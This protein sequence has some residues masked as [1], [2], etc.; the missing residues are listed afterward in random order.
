MECVSDLTL[1]K[2]SSRIKAEPIIITLMIITPNKGN[3]F[4]F[5][6]LITEIP[7]DVKVYAISFMLKFLVLN[8]RIAKMA[9]KPKAIPISMKTEFSMEHMKKTI[10]AIKKKVNKNFSFFVY[11]K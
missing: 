7:I 3:L 4:S 11:L 10:M 8:L 2:N 9:N 6:E 1:T 5:N